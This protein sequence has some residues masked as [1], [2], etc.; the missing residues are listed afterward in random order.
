[1]TMVEGALQIKCGSEPMTVQARLCQPD[2][3]DKIVAKMEESGLVS[4][5][6]S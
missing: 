2:E 4:Y 1:M 6:I 5:V 3:F